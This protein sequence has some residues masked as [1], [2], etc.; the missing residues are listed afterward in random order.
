VNAN[1][2]F[3]WR[4]GMILRI[5]AKLFRPVG[6]IMLM[7]LLCFKMGADPLVSSWYTEKSGVYARLY[8]NLSDLE[9]QRA[10]T[11]W[12]R[13][14]GTQTLPVYAGVQGIA[15]SAAWV[16]IKTSG[17]GTHV[18]GPWFLNDGKTQDFPNFPSNTATLYRFPRTP[19]IPQNKTDTSAG[20]IGYFVD[21]ISMFDSTD[22]F[23]YDTSQAV[24]QNPGNTANGDEVWNRDA[25]INEGVTFDNANAHQAG[26]M[27]HYHANPPAL[28]H[29]LGD[30]V[31]F[32]VETNRY[33]EH[34]NGQHSPIIGWVSDGL[35]IYGPYGYD[36]PDT[37]SNDMG[38]R[39]MITGYQLRDGSRG[40]D[41][42]TK[43][44]RTSLPQWCQQLQG[45]AS[46]LATSQYGPDVDALIQ[47]ETYILGRYF[48]DYTYKG[49]LDLVLGTDFDLNAHNV[50][51]GRTPEFPEGTWAYFTCILE[52]GT[53]TFPYNI[54][55]QF[56][57]NPVGGS[58]A[59]ME[60]VTAV[61]FKGGPEKPDR[62]DQ[63]EVD[64]DMLT[65]SWSLVEGGTYRVD[66]SDDLEIW[67][68][69]GL[70]LTS[71]KDTSMLE[72]ALEQTALSK[73]FYR[74]ERTSLDAY[75][76]SE[77]GET[78]VGGGGEGPPPNGRPPF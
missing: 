77:F 52:D 73:R 33:T 63:I 27:H 7:V 28:R 46:A 58:V 67:N 11:T 20:V 6:S 47:G 14:Q 1:I 60:D 21:G 56:Y 31:D 65:I 26:N 4:F 32:D 34:F 23:S 71:S 42:L 55:T 72:E 22:T 30:S 48:E 36:N 50:R 54:A 45:R 25:F 37:A 70:P 9:A 16:Y 24:D 19:T 74:V 62:L 35:P 41:D 69:S 64:N 18:M 12:S 61:V 78:V 10:S 44:G 66:T 75:D 53:P 17:L 49:D 15:H 57:G 43:T 2:H 39:R 40:S 76:D 68:P 38:V 59:S 51:F 8:E 3:Y 5:C 13:G 29:A